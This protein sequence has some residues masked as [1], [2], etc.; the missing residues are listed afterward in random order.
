MHGILSFEAH[1]H[2]KCFCALV[3]AGTINPT[4]DLHH[5]AHDGYGC[6]QRLGGALSPDGIVAKDMKEVAV[7]DLAKAQADLVI[8]TKADAVAT[9]GASKSTDLAVH[10]IFIAVP[11]QLCKRTSHQGH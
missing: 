1:A 10:A 4:T 8:P 9:E 2:S 11:G 6:R 5:V 3:A 7:K